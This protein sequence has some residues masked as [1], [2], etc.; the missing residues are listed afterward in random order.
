MRKKL[1][2]TLIA[3]S[4]LVLAA[5]TTWAW[6]G[7]A[8]CLGW[9]YGP[10]WSQAPVNSQA[11]AKFQRDTLELRQKLAAKNQEL[12]TLYAQ[13]Q[14]DQARIASVNQEIA[15]LRAELIKKAGEAGLPAGGYG[16]GW[17]GRGFARGWGH[18]G[19]CWY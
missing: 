2:T 10:A 9:G 8:Y 7:S 5:G 4:I 6:W 19:P 14:P 16:Y 15:G 17:P 1:G 11:W 13:P 18:H 12:A 3:L